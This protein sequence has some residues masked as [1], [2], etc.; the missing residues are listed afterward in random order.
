MMLHSREEASQGGHD[1]G[2]V[3]LCSWLIAAEQVGEM[4]DSEHAEV[5][6][7]EHS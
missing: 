3:Y 4:Q 1:V 5:N 6:A 2:I 7:G